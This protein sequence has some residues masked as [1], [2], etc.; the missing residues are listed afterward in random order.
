[1]TRETWFRLCAVACAIGPLAADDTRGAFSVAML[2]L[3]V[4]SIKP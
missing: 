4:W 2:G 1:M 3:V